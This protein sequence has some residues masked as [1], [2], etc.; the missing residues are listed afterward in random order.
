M[1]VYRHLKGGCP[2]LTMAGLLAV[3]AV[4]ACAAM[5]EAAPDPD[6]RPAGPAAQPQARPAGAPRDWT[7]GQGHWALVWLGEAVVAADGDRGPPDIRFQPENG[8]GR[9]SGHGGC[10]RFMGSYRVK[11]GQVDFSRLA[12]TRMACADDDG[13]E[14]RFLAA[15]ERTRRMTL[16]D[17][18]RLTFLDASGAPLA[19]FRRAEAAHP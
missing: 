14:T 11:G 17:G 12:V 7:P 2:A 4:T 15:L 10:N 13:L 6:T 3:L 1:T 16:D 5:P 9:V 18:G 8:G 19:R